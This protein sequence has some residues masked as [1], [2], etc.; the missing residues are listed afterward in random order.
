MG[1]KEFEVEGYWVRSPYADPGSKEA[2]PLIPFLLQINPGAQAS[3][4]IMLRL[5][6]K[7][8]AA[9]ERLIHRE[10]GKPQ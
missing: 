3:S 2:R 8:M 9:A 6:C 10:L 7:A 4:L 1:G 5:I